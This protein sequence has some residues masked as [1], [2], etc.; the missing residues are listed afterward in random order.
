MD[1]LLTRPV[2][3]PAFIVGKFLAQLVCTQFEYL[4]AFAVLY[5]V[6]VYRHVP[7]L[8]GPVPLLLL[9]Q[10]LMIT[11]FSAFGFF[12]WLLSSR[13]VIIGL[14][15]GV[16]VEIGVGQIPTQLNRLSMIHQMRMMFPNF[17]FPMDVVTPH[18]AASPVTTTAIVLAMTLFLLAATV[19]VFHLK[20]LAG[21]QGKEA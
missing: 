10:L 1:Y 5:G 2:P 21:A 20:E 19:L 6:G 9:A 12:F 13:Y 18:A 14:C 4:L 11:V 7:D 8:A 17:I 16:V 3:R 15:Y